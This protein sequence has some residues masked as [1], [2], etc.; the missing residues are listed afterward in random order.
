MTA[1]LARG[2][3]L[4]VKTAFAFAGL[5]KSVF[6][7]SLGKLLNLPFKIRCNHRVFANGLLTSATKVWGSPAI[8][9]NISNPAIFRT[10]P[11][12]IRGIS[13]QSICG[14][15]KKDSGLHGIFAF[16]TTSIHCAR[17]L[18]EGFNYSDRLSIGSVSM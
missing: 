5:M 1:F 6:G 11:N 9:I 4:S 12:S 2:F 8:R 3:T 16:M 10:S 7:V 13:R 15:D 18:R 14:G 17:P